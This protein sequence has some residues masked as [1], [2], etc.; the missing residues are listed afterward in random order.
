M[1][2]SLL[3]IADDNFLTKMETKNKTHIPVLYNSVLRELSLSK[4][5]ANIIVDATLWL[6]GHANGF[7]SQFGSNDIYIGIDRDEFNCKT[8]QDRLQSQFPPLFATHQ[9]HCIHSSFSRLTDILTQT[10]ISAPTAILY[11]LGISSVH[12][13]DT[14][15]G[16][17]FRFDAPLDMRFDRTGN[18]PTAANFV[19]TA[20]LED[21]YAVLKKYGEEPKAKF[22][23]QAI[24]ANREN[25]PIQTS[26]QLANIVKQASFDPKSTL[27]TFQAIRIAVND[28][29]W[30]IEESLRQA[31]QI[32][33]PGWKIAVISF[34]SLEDRLI[35]H[36]FAEVCEDEIND[37]T[38][39]IQK[40][41]KFQKITKKPIIP[42]TEEQNTNPRARSAKMRI[43][44]KVL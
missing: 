10:K 16:F 23:A 40:R 12:A 17:S 35:K 11:D 4:N 5:T 14:E 34:H 44:Q 15:H 42:D 18:L 30:E 21:I 7:L 38:G 29:F 20:T 32:L 43:I 22:I 36:M 1:Q 6:G 27:R 9:I 28:E 8:A 24:V 26:G 41:A 39:Q 13:D 25:E 33:A 31:F 3:F 19:N 2:W 37:L